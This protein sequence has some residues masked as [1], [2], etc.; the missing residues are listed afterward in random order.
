MEW[1]EIIGMVVVLF[2]GLYLGC[3][4]HELKKNMY[5]NDSWKST[6]K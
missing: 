3:K 5:N 6:K 4:F 2:V 1:N